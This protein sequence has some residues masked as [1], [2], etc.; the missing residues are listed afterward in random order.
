V[1][2]G[3]TTSPTRTASSGDAMSCAPCVE[4]RSTETTWAESWTGLGSSQPASQ[5][6]EA[7][8]AAR[9]TATL[10]GGVRTCTQRTT[11]KYTHV[12]THA[13]HSA[14]NTHIRT[15]THN[16]ARGSRQGHGPAAVWRGP[17]CAHLLFPHAW[18]DEVGLKQLPRHRVA[19]ARLQ[20]LPARRQLHH[21]RPEQGQCHSGL[22]QCGMALAHTKTACAWKLCIT[23]RCCSPVLPKNGTSSWLAGTCALLSKA[24][25]IA[26]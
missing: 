4:K 15:H 10:N 20:Q 13:T 18:R 22:G 21:L 23:L 5:P 8:T 19:H 1:A 11:H 14:H 7:A 6:T 17:P 12:F 24:L 3:Y 2:Q 25:L 26:G 9:L 16:P